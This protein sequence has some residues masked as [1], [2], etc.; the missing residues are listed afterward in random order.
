MASAYTELIKNGTITSGAGFLKVCCREFGVCA[1]MK[2]AS[3]TSPIPKHFEADE[4]YKK[5]YDKAAREWAKWQRISLDE[6]RKIMVL[7]HEKDLESKKKSL[8]DWQLE[9]QKFQKILHEVEFWIAP[10][11]QHE[12][13]KKF[14]LSQLN[15]TMHSQK[16]IDNLQASIDAV[17][18]TGDEAVKAYID[19]Q[20][21]WVEMK[22]ERTYK[23]WGE[24]MKDAA[25]KNVWMKQFL[26]SLELMESRRNKKTIFL[27]A[28]R[29]AVGKSSLAREACKR[30]GLK[31]VKSYTTRPMRPNEDSE[32][33]DHIFITPEEVEQFRQDIV[34]YTRI[35]G[36]EYFVT[37][38][39]L[40]QSDVYVIDPNGI[41]SLI[42]NVGE[43]YR[44]VQIYISTP[45]KIALERA[46]KRGDKHFEER[47]IS[48]NS[49]F[50]QY[51]KNEPWD[52]FIG[53]TGDFESTVELLVDIMNNKW[54]E[55]NIE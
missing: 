46:I 48:E 35:N 39:I 16:S 12:N 50:E 7:Q 19:K 18:D 45:Y 3:L 5:E 43:S 21:Q 54:K 47:R 55:K 23:Q 52:Y 49:Q 6:A 41:D 11:P 30:L 34:A 36:Y 15:Y 13:L 4:F 17:L 33:S 26:E 20:K 32:T 51:E 37:S 14:A 10:T 44:F 38:D 8:I 2:D 42:R 25:D 22:V 53:N 28:G 40:S 9:N 24:S 27:I 31:M 1:N 29:S